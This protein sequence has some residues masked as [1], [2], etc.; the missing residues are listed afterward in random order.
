MNHNSAS[1]YLTTVKQRAGSEK[2]K[3]KKI[4]NLRKP[5]GFH[6]NACWQE[7]SKITRREGEI[8]REKKTEQKTFKKKGSN[9]KSMISFM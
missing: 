4:K 2:K 6:I 7:A 1:V 3:K 8:G 5:A 9:I